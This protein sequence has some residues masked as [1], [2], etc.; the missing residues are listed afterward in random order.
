MP[1]KTG[2]IIN[3]ASTAAFQ[4][5]PSF[6]SYAATKAYVLSFSEAIEY[7]LKPFGINVTT[8]CPGATQSEFATVAKANDKVFAKAPSSYDLALFTFNAYKKNKGTAIHGL[9]NSIMVF[10]LRF[11]PRKM[12]TKIAAIIMK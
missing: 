1:K 8:I 4:A 12:A 10:G 7:E 9:I 11:T 2:H 3:I 6:S 5:V